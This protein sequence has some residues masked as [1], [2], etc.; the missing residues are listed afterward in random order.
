MTVHMVNLT[1]P[2]MMKGPFREFI[3]V[4][5]H[6]SIKIPQDAKVKGV[7]LLVSGQKPV[8]QLNKGIVILTVPKIQD[9]EIVGLELA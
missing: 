7:H 1:N 5:A 4:D 3:P 2:M 6:V 9:Y 8:F